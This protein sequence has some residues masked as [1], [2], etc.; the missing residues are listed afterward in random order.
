ME[1][2]RRG[3][4]LAGRQEAVQD[5]AATITSTHVIKAQ[6]EP[7][8]P[9][10]QQPPP[11]SALLLC[12]RPQECNQAFFSHRCLMGSPKARLDTIRQHL[13]SDKSEMTT[14]GSCMCGA[15]KYEFTGEPKVTALCHCTDCQKVHY[16]ET[17]ANF[18]R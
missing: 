3:G 2:R 17:S 4:I 6:F 16:P 8:S 12:I 18:F 13:A 1:R 14:T 7:R 5:R 10:T 15:V 9:S 11:S